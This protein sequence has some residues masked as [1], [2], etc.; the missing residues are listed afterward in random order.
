MATVTV[1][2]ESDK[3]AGKKDVT[4]LRGALDWLR[5]TGNL[6]ETDKE[7]NPDLE[8]TGLQKHFDGGP[9]ILF[10]NVK[11]KPHARA[12]TSSTAV[13]TCPNQSAKRKREAAKPMRATPPRICAPCR[14]GRTEKSNGRSATSKPTDFR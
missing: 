1:P 13:V 7:V 14:P 12:I 9:C 6:I 3:K 4:N 11:G 10:N 5:S 2:K 8:I